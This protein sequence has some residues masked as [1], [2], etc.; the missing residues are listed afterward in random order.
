MHLDIC[1][2]K[3]PKEPFE[4]IF[5]ELDQKET[6]YCLHSNGNE[7]MQF[8]LFTRIEPS[9]EY[10]AIKDSFC[11]SIAEECWICKGYTPV[12]FHFEPYLLPQEQFEMLKNA[13]HI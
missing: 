13:I 5:N 12:R 2:C 7:E 10:L 3:L 6:F 11:L 9:L 1:F 8:K 4:S